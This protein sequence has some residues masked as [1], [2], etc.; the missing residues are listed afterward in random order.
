VNG[1]PQLTAKGETMNPQITII[2]S[3]EK[4]DQKKAEAVLAAIP[5]LNGQIVSPSRGF[6]EGAAKAI[7]WVG[8]FVGGS[9]KIADLLIEQATKELAGA[10]IEIQV[11]NAVVKVNNVN[12]SQ[13]IELLNQSAEIAKAQ[14]SL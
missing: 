5:E 6:A 10:S 1:K 8:E 13:V 3:G 14:N 12:R 11:G 7:K 9:S 4:V 2:A